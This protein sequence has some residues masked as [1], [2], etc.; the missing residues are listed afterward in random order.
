M[1]NEPL[2]EDENEE[3]EDENENLVNVFINWD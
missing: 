3:S 2:N 1:E